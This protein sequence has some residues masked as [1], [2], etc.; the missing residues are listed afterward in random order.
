MPDNNQIR[1]LIVDDQVDA[2]EALAQMLE[3]PQR[4]L[5]VVH[6]GP[7][8]L[9]V[10]A[11]FDPHL[12]FIDILL[13]GINGYDVARAMRKMVG[14]NRPFLVALTGWERESQHSKSRA[15][16]FDEHLL[17]PIDWVTAERMLAKVTASNDFA[18]K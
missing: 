5:R 15:A 14:V 8:A 16:G 1:I 13:P 11:V 9:A 3:N 7:D 18:R 17:K 12:A 6:S 10:A 2:A 4:E